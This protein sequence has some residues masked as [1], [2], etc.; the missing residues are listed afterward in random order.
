M[1]DRRG[2]ALEKEE[3]HD[4]RSHSRDRPCE[5]QLPGLR[6][7][8]GRGVYGCPQF[9]K[10]IFGQ[11]RRCGASIARVSGLSMWPNIRHG[12]L[13]S[14]KSQIHIGSESFDAQAPGVVSSSC[15]LKSL[16]HNSSVDLLAGACGPEVLPTLPSVEEQWFA[17]SDNSLP[18][19]SSP[20]S[21]APSCWPRQRPPPCGA[22]TFVS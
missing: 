12:P 20:R 4:G 2:I 18:A 3:A 15:T 8:P 10:V 17:P 14:S 22:Y 21:C 5:A 7:G 1:S 9:C 6:H 19:S 16:P 13:C 11:L